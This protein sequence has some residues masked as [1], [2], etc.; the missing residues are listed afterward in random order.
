MGSC[1]CPGSMEG[2]NRQLGQPTRCQPH[3][4]GTL[5]TTAATLLASL[6]RS[7]TTKKASTSTGTTDHHIRQDT[8]ASYMSPSDCVGPTPKPRPD[9]F[10]VF[11]CGARTGS[12]RPARTA[13]RGCRS[14]APA[15]PRPASYRE[16]APAGAR[17]TSHDPGATSRRPPGAPSARVRPPSPAESG[18]P[19]S[20]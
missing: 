18:A 14:R 5:L 6:L 19:A 8:N 20:R 13:G 9:Q 10:L 4:C 17:G 15:S 1:Q 16:L 2:S 11:C 12:A 3:W 7:A